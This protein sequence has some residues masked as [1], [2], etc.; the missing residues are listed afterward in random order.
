MPQ[1]AR[2]HVARLG[3]LGLVPEEEPG[4]AEDLLH[5][6]LEDLRVGEDPPRDQPLIGVDERFEVGLGSEIRP[7]WRRQ[8]VH[9]KR[10]MYTVGSF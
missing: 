9:A 3:D 5:L 4:P 6:E 10:I 2:D 1:R 7:Q 8:G